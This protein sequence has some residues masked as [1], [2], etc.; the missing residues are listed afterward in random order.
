[1]PLVI[2]I[3]LSALAAVTLFA[4]GRHRGLPAEEAA[5]QVAGGALLLDV[6]TAGEF[7]TEHAP[8]AI[9]IP[10]HALPTRLGQLPTDQRLLV[11]CAHGPRSLAAAGILRAAGCP[12]TPVRGGMAAWPGIE[13]RAHS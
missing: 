8:G 7:A 3:S 11:L 2:L 12:A 6:R 10:L 9:N 5:R 4:G 13:R 1:M